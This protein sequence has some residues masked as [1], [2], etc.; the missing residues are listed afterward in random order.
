MTSARRT[1]VQER[2]T[3][4]VQSILA[5]AS[6]LLAK[7][8]LEQIT[9]SRIA[10]E[11]GVSVGGLYRFFPDK[12]AIVDAIAVQRVEEFQRAV[13]GRLASMESLDGPKLLDLMIDVYVGFLE[14]HPDF[15]TIALGRH[16]SALTK[17]QQV[18]PGAGPGNLL[19]LF[20]PDSPEL[21]LKLRIAIETGER[22]IDFAFGQSSQEMKARVIE[23]MKRL[24]S[25][26]LF[27]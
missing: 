10:Q 27:G 13:E 26:Y 11:A 19:K 8:P 18:E 15:R 24:L 25:S 17:E 16:V 22:L 20:L 23:E 9:T 2:S 7:T 5:A 6:A 21:D 1:P 14:A 12:Q 3:D 4:T